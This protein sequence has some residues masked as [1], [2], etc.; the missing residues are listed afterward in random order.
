MAWHG[1]VSDCAEYGAGRRLRWLEGNQALHLQESESGVADR[2]CVGALCAAPSFPYID[3]SISYLDS[4]GLSNYNAL[5]AKLQ[6]HFGSG[7]S[8]L[9][10]YT[11]S[12]AL[13]DSSNANL[14]AQNND[15]FRWSAHPELEYGSLDFDVRHRF[16]ASYIWDLPIGKDKRFAPNLNSAAICFSAT[17]SSPAL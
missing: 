16:L 9:V 15:S 14:G 2:G 12:H 13:G 10:N 4:E 6:H 5:Q 11:Y 17:G 1:A 3:S 8:A 7:V